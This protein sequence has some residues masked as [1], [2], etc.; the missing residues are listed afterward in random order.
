MQNIK[1][2]NGNQ[3]IQSTV[4]PHRGWHAT[5][6]HPHTF[7]TMANAEPACRGTLAIDMLAFMRQSP[8][9]GYRSR[10]WPVHIRRAPLAGVKLKS[11][12]RL[13]RTRFAFRRWLI[14]VTT[15]R[16]ELEHAANI[17]KVDQTMRCGQYSFG[18][19][20]DIEEGKKHSGPGK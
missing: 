9:G 11:I 8:Y 16:M 14:R 5:I 7:K 12:S 3:I 15:S 2:T 10:A 4:G 19:T 6:T 20:T 13:T 1:R 18:L 17:L